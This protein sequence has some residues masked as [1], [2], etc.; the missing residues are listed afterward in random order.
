MASKRTEYD[1]SFKLEV[2]RMVIDQGLAVA[3]VV[4]DMKVGR[5]SVDRWVAQYLAEKNG[6]PGIGKPLTAEQQRIRQLKS[7][8]ELLKKPRPSLPAN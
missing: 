1:A 6:Q 4:N 2:A 7:D 8:N 3:E 5:T